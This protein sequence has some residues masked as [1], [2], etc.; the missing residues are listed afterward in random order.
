MFQAVPFV[1]ARQ[2][3]TAATTDRTVSAFI[4][5]QLLQLLQQCQL[6]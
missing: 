2:V 5:K 1:T 3:A 6:Y 4:W